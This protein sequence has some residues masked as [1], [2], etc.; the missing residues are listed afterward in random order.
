MREEALE[1][2][3]IDYWNK[4]PIVVNVIDLEE[5]SIDYIH[6]QNDGEKLKEEEVILDYY[7]NNITQSY[8]QKREEAMSIDCDYSLT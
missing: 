6:I 3:A 5:M 1:D 2:R 4:Q 7:K 8:C